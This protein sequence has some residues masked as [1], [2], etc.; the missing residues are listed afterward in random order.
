MSR[1]V[2]DLQIRGVALLT[3]IGHP[4]DHCMVQ[5]LGGPWGAVVGCKVR[6][7]RDR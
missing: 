2:G 1:F 7:L 4:L 3:S 5:L 6:Y